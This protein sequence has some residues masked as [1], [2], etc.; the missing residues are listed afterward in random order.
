M[1]ESSTVVEAVA[2]ATQSRKALGQS[3]Q[4]AMSGAVISAS[5]EA[6]K[7]WG[8]PSLSLEVRQQKISELMEPAAL[9]RRMLTAREV[10]RRTAAP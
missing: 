6:E 8:D 4:D 10:T 5:K 7:I 3:I 2:V 1:D 9:K